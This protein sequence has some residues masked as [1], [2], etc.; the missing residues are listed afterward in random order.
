MCVNHAG[1]GTVRPAPPVCFIAPPNVLAYVIEKGDDEQRDAAL[2]TL[3]SSASLRTQRSIVASVM[4]TLDVDAQ[5]LGFL[6][7]PTGRQR[8]VYDVQN[9]GRSALPGQL[10]RKEGDDPVAD[11]AVNEAYDGAGKTY[12]FYRDVLNRDSIDG[13]GLELVSSV[14]YGVRFENALWNGVQMIYGDGGGRLFVKGSL[15]K[16]L[17]VIAHELTH[18]VTQY[19]AGLEYSKQS[20]A[21]NESWSDV[22]GSL[23]KQYS[24]GE[25]AEQAD[26]LIGEGIFAPGLGA[27]LRSMK[28]PGTAW[29][30]D[31]QPATMEDY[32]DLPDDNDPA[33]RQRRRPHQLGHPQPRLLPH[34]DRARRTRLGAG[35]QDLVRGADQAP[36]TDVAV[37]RRRS[38]D[39]RGGRQPVRLHRAAGGRVGVEAGGRPAMIQE[40][41]LSIVRGGGIAGIATRTELAD[42]ALPPDAAE[43]LRER[44]KAVVPPVERALRPR[45][46]PDETLY[47]VRVDHD[48]ET[49]DVHYTDST[50][51][52][53][54]RLLIAWADER[55]ERRERIEPP[56]R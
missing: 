21:L 5:S 39:Q 13:K 54:V 7:A 8:T 37:R 43:E 2:R 45:P 18:G 47:T 16:S 35:G 49:T 46:Q 33:E 6:P 26:W 53:D 12:D 31:N 41:K 38:R 56:A 29:Q 42:D 52:E 23:V 36:A 48:G 50:L 30:G 28:A 1:H 20:G 4:R 40:V 44:A 11:V 10:E 25:T 3:A 34:G 32:V 19:T 55:P 15:T 22:F 24:Q 51:P 14:H 9:G 27:A 17:D